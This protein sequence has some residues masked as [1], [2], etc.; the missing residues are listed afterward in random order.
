MTM[1][2]YDMNAT[3]FLA[4]RSEYDNVSLEDHKFN[5]FSFKERSVMESTLAA[6]P[7]YQAAFRQRQ[8]GPGVYPQKK[9]EERP[10]ATLTKAEEL[11]LQKTN[12]NKSFIEKSKAAAKNKNAGKEH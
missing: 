8:Q 11:V 3:L 7:E 4:N 5:V 6:L 1:W 2:L 9:E 10:K 12:Q